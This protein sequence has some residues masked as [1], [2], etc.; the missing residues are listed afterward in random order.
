MA[1]ETEIKALDDKRNQLLA[2]GRRMVERSEKENRNLTPTEQS[3][4]DKINTD[5]NETDKRIERMQSLRDSESDDDDE[6]ERDDSDDEEEKKSRKKRKKRDDDKKD[7]D[8]DERDDSDDEDKDEDDERSYVRL[9][10]G[11]LAVPV[12]KGR[13]NNSK[14]PRPNSVESRAMQP[15]PGE[16]RTDFETR[17]RRNSSEYRSAAFQYLAFGPQ[18]LNAK[19]A[20]AIQADTDIS[21]GYLVMPQQFVAQLIKFVDN[22]VFIR[23]KATK[24]VVANAQTVGAPSLDNDP[25]DSD[26]TSELATGNEDTT[27]SVR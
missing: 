2:E 18:S 15:F 9:P 22:L 25:A 3:Q 4:W 16:S 1:F 17:A 20:R 8:D 11:R 14:R 21:G 27:M 23:D 12:G 5:I 6:D 19:Q 10:D 26:W 13:R 7:G 24:L